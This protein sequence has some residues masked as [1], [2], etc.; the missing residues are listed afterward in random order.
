MWWR[1][2][3]KKKKKTET[4]YKILFYQQARLSNYT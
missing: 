1:K 2:R 4:M 3:S